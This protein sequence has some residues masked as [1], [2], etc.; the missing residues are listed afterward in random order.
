[1]LKC[2]KGGEITKI[3]NIFKR[4]ELK[5]IL[6]QNQAETVI[7]EI[8]KHM[9]VD[10]F[11]ETDILNIYYD[12]PDGRL[13]RN[14]IDKPDY[15]EKLRLRCYGVPS[16]NSPAFIELKK[17][18]DSIVYKRRLPATYGQAVSFLETGKLPDTQIGRE[19]EYFLQFYKT[20]APSMVVTYHRKAY[21]S[22][23]FRATFDSNILFR[24]RDLDLRSGIYGEQVTDK[25]IMELKSAN[26]IPFWLLRVLSENKI[27]KQPFSKYGTA[28]KKVKGEQY[29]G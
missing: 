13:I 19:I 29:N 11:G 21:L 22:G 5:Y 18:Y 26:A 10:P 27:Y 12:T 2:R 14:S 1:M 4:Y 20:L 6:T 23:E 15:K 3:K 7:K 17:K 9:E 8:E 25:V 24:T 16:D 28:Y